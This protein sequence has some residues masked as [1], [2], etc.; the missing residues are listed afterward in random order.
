MGADLRRSQGVKPNQRHIHHSR[1]EFTPRFRTSRTKNDVCI[2]GQSKPPVIRLDSLVRHS[3][4]TSLD[5]C[6]IFWRI[7]SS[8]RAHLIEGEILMRLTQIAFALVFLCVMVVVPCLAQIEHAT[9]SGRITD[10]TGA[11]IL[12]VTVQLTSAERGTVGETTTNE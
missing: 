10:S 1:R 5:R 4:G 9:I 6:K 12:G 3:G 11:V 2:P 8:S 7:F